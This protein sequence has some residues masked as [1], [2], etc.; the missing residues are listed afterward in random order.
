M[1]TTP[2]FLLSLLHTA[3]VSLLNILDLDGANVDVGA[4]FS[5]HQHFHDQHFHDRPWYERIHSKLSVESRERS[6][7]V[8]EQ[9]G[10]RQVGSG[11]LLSSP[12][13]K[14]CLVLCQIKGP[15]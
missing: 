7:K 5:T 9:C 8:L 14:R 1:T 2:H 3:Q 13:L 12:S 10:A 4:K 6:E 15:Q 11:E